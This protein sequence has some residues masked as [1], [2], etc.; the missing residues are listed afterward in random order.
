MSTKATGSGPSLVRTYGPILAVVALLALVP[1]R[2]HD[3][4][5]MMGVIIGGLLFAAY[6][7]AFNIIF[8]STGQLFL[9]LGALGGIG[10]FGSVILSDRVGIPMVASIVIAGMIS[11]LVGGALSWIAVSRSL[12]VIFTGIVTNGG[13]ASTVR[14]AHVRDFRCIVLKD[15]CAAFDLTT[16]ETAIAALSDIA[17]ISTC[18]Q[19]GAALRR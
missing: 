2:Y 6:A 4:R 14:D 19:V 7:V 10:G 18:A 15:G 3:S 13:V 1:L 16:H 5:A 8:G 12:D 11:A 17:E 9:C